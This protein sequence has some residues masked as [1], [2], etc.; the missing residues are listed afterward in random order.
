[1]TLLPEA[2]TSLNESSHPVRW[3][4]VRKLA[5]EK[6]RCLGSSSTLCLFPCQLCD[7]TAWAS[8]EML[9]WI[10]E[11]RRLF[12]FKM[13]DFSFCVILMQHFVN[14]KTESGGYWQF[15]GWLVS[16][17]IVRWCRSRIFCTGSHVDEDKHRHSCRLV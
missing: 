15:I 10:Y 7:I 3:W 17:L 5:S 2:E 6:C 4:D 1:M 14:L 12:P 13:P 11:W 16:Q 8:S 9:L